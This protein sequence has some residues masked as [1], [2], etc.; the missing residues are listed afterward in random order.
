GVS[1]TPV[2][3]ALLALERQGL[4]RFERNRGVRVLES[5]AHD[6]DEIFGL[7]LLL[8]VPITRDAAERFDEHDLADLERLI[9]RMAEHVDD[10]DDTAFMQLDREF[11]ER[12]LRAAGNR[13]LLE[14]VAG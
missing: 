5:S 14:V 12:V 10:P 8:E 7:R 6:L 9:A 1:R 3:E 13:R 2:R 4:V 11:H